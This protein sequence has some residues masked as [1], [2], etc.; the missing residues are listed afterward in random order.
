MNGT[1]YGDILRK[2]ADLIASGHTDTDL[3]EGPERTYT[4]RLVRRAAASGVIGAAVIYPPS[5]S[6]RDE[7]S[8]ALHRSYAVAA[9][10]VLPENES[11]FHG[12]MI[13]AVDIIRNV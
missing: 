6:S 7:V 2:Y 8:A 12:A 1:T 9:I 10:G 3:P 4:E 11:A 13:R 5:D